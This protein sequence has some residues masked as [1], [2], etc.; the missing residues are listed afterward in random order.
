MGGSVGVVGLPAWLRRL[1]RGFDKQY[2]DWGPHEDIV[3][4]IEPK[5]LYI[6]ISFRTVSCTT[7][8]ALPTPLRW[9]IGLQ[10]CFHVG[11][12]LDCKLSILAQMNHYLAYDMRRLQQLAIIN[13]IVASTFVLGSSFA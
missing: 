9:R 12:I 13:L 7:E 11:L 8:T 3:K 6:C 1:I 10:A 5:T 4:P 2:V